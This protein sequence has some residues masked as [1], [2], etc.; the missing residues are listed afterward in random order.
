[1]TNKFAR[2]NLLSQEELARYHTLPSAT[3][4]ASP[5][6]PLDSS[7][8]RNAIISATSCGAAGFGKRTL[9]LRHATT[10]ALQLHALFC[11]PRP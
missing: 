6:T 4:I 9:L 2:D 3:L 11:G 8:A 7:D 10:E 5:L 1:M